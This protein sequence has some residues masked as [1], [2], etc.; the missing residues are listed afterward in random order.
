MPTARDSCADDLALL[1]L[2]D[3]DTVW[4]LSEAFLAANSI[5]D[6]AYLPLSNVVFNHTTNRYEAATNTAGLNEDDWI[7]HAMVMWNL[8]RLELGWG[9]QRMLRQLSIW[10]NPECPSESNLPNHWRAEIQK[11]KTTKKPEKKKKKKKTTKRL[12]ETGTMML[13]KGLEN[14]DNFDKTKRNMAVTNCT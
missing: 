8:R 4:K 6:E 11:L 14:H 3:D 12:T 2:L 7:L 13:G 10:A 1:A 9:L 5:D